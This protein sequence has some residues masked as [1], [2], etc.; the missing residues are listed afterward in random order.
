[1]LAEVFDENVEYVEFIVALTEIVVF[2]PFAVVV[3][4]SIK[5]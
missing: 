4:V 1:V 3:F 2:V 5:V